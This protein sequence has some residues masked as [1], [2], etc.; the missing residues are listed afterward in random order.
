M[1]T[2]SDADRSAGEALARSL[3]ELADIK[4][5]LD[6]SAIVAITDHRGLITFAND[7]FCRI[8]GYSREELLGQDH[9]IVNSGFHP[10]EYFRELWATIASG[11]IWKGEIRNRAKNGTYYWV[12]T[13]IVPLLG[14]DGRPEQY[15]SIRT[16]ITARKRLEAEAVRTAQVSM[17]A[18]LSV[19]LAH[20][21]KNP[22][23]GIQGAVDIMLR[24]RGPDDPERD[25]LESVRGEV[26]RIDAT[27]RAI[28]DLARPRAAD[29]D[30][31]S[32]AAAVERAVTL[33]R[34][35]IHLLG[36]P[37]DV[38][39]AP[40]EE[41]VVLSMDAPQIEAAVFSLLIN[42]VEAIDADGRIV[43][44]LRAT[45]GEAVVE[46]EDS[47]RGIPSWDL[48]RVFQPFYSTKPGG[49]GLGLGTVQR[50]A[51]AHGG[52]VDGASVPGRGSLFAIR[53]P[54]GLAHTRAARDS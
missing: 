10:K 26:A 14:D 19:G 31:A 54:R 25:S 22:L 9:R 44:R 32:L 36:L 40:C 50:I 28:V 15:V 45:A 27:V 5:A 4:R 49:P 12:D 48:K 38:A 18:E 30:A 6:A 13:T 33:A 41:D 42:A 2:P 39:L 3:R 51:R 23:A 37:I 35:R 11:R 20:E 21:I 52:R 47:G 17:L 1:C 7:N 24:R 53:L 29:R 8:S 16:D 43:V 46:V 34:D